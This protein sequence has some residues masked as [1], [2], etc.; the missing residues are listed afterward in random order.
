MSTNKWEGRLVSSKDAIHSELSFKIRS[1]I[2]EGIDIFDETA[3][4]VELLKMIEEIYF[5]DVS[6]SDD[7]L[8]VKQKVLKTL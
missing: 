4:V 7:T 2:K 6:L 8:Y 3:N 5:Q 1:L